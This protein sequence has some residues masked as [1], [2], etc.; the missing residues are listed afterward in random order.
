MPQ[1]PTLQVTGAGI[2]MGF[3]SKQIPFFGIHLSM[4]TVV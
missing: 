1:V 3:A 2:L 4:D